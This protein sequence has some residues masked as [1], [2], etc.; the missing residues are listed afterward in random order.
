MAL[1]LFGALDCKEYV[2]ARP[3]V[4][5]LEFQVEEPVFGRV[6]SLNVPVDTG[7]AGYLLLPRGLYDELAT[8]ER[9]REDFGV[10]VTLSGPIVLRRAEAVVS[11]CSKKFNTF[12]ET[13]LHGIGKLLVGRRIISNLDLALLGSRETCCRLQSVSE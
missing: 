2:G 1:E 8:L 4:P 10:Y 11:V 5:S 3:G 9:P 13:P 7:F 6:K 12:I